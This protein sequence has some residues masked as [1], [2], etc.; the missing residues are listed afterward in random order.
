MSDDYEDDYVPDMLDD[1]FDRQ[2]KFMTLLKDHD[3]CPEFP[4]DITGKAGQ[5]LIRENLL[6]MIEELM[7]A[8]FC[9]RNK[10]HRLTDVRVF[11]F[12]HYREELG[13]AL[14][15]FMEVCILSG[16]T[17]DDIYEEYKRKNAVVTKRL[18]EGY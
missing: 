8:S 4:I 9:L 17:A 1:M 18:E 13:D 10:M 2:T 11:D 5:R 15:F 12:E 14:A 16:I 7:E 6:N 3:K